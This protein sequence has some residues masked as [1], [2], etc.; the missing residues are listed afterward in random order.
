[1]PCCLT[2]CQSPASSFVHYAP[3]GFLC[4]SEII[5]T[6][7]LV[8]SHYLILDKGTIALADGERKNDVRVRWMPVYA[9]YLVQ[10]LTV[11]R[12]KPPHSL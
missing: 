5:S 9:Q 10:L 1:M 11:S 6:N 4:S 2:E 12:F 3:D 8:H 7:D